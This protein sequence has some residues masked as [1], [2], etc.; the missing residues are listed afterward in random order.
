MR[1]ARCKSVRMSP[2]TVALCMISCC[3]DPVGGG[4][5]QGAWD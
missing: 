4:V 3:N 2:G 1:P 5:E